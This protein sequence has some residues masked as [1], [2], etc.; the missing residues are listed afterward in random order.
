MQIVLL[1]LDNFNPKPHF[2]KVEE[3]YLIRL[4]NEKFE[5]HPQIMPLESWIVD[6]LQCI[7]YTTLTDALCCQFYVHKESVE[8]FSFF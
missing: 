4:H 8:S 5:T 1:E 7:L 6:S 3:Y 2:R